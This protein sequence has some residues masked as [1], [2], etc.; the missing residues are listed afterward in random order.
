VPCTLQALQ[1]CTAGKPQADAL[2]VHRPPALHNSMLERFKQR[3]AQHS[4]SSNH[5]MGE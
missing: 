3:L 5:G 2:A 4:S 1:A